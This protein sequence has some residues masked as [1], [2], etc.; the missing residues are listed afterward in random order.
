MPVDRDADGLELPVL[1]GVDGTFTTR[2]N[3][4][5]AG[6]AKA[7]GVRGI[8]SLNSMPLYLNTINPAVRSL[9][10]LGERVSNPDSQ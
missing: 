10:D 3:G 2:V 5:T 9:R 7:L 8:A 6:T 1:S 4:L